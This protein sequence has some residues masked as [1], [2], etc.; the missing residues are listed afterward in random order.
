MEITTTTSYPLPRG[1]AARLIVVGSAIV[2]PAL[3]L[4]ALDRPQ[5]AVLPLLACFFIWFLTTPRLSL[6]LFLV[7]L[8]IYL[9]YYTGYFAIHLMDVALVLLVAGV[10]LE[11]LLRGS[12]EIR[13][14][15][16]DRAFIVLILATVLSAIFA[17]NYRLSIVPIVR[18]LTLYIAFRMLF[19]YAT[20]IPIRR[21]I[22]Y[23]LLLVFVL[24]VISVVEL[25][26]TRGSLRIFGPAVLAMQYFTMTALPMVLC[27]F[28]WEPRAQRRW[29]YALYAGFFVIAMLAT[30]SRA[31]MVAT[32]ISMPVLIWVLYRNL[33]HERHTVAWRN[34]TLIFAVVAVMAAVTIVLSGTLFAGTFARVAEFIASFKSPKGT[35]ALRLVLWSAALEA[36]LKH[37]VL[38][39][40]IGNFR[41]VD[42]ILPHL[43]FTPT[44]RWVRGMSAHNVLL[45]YLAETGLVG[46]LSLLALAVSG[47]RMARRTLREQLSVVEAPVAAALY[48]AMF[49]FCVTLLY[50]RAWTWEQGGY[51][52]AFIFALNAAWRYRRRSAATA[53]AKR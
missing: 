11:F 23:Y 38:G 40:G 47:Y 52:M 33:R 45:H 28:V 16:F 26:L 53:S 27:L 43:K 21:L 5:L 18:I 2:V 48:M 41:V 39:I 1:A 50:M 36:F 35:V 22:E 20:E 8:G 25:A 37:P 24:S 46:T 14:T 15:G 42:D 13:A 10:V 29:R 12:T 32:V 44:W 4:V 6:Y 30:Q 17:H 19:K 9:P 7:S 3:T 49:M 51:L 34:L 31:P